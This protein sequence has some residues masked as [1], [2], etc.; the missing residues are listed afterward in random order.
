LLAE[1]NCDLQRILSRRLNLLGLEVVSVT[2]GREAVTLAQAALV[3]EKPFDLIL[4][5]I[6]MPIVDGYEATRQ[7][8]D[9]GFSGPILAL[10]AHSAEDYRQE[11][12]K[13]GCNDCI[14]KPIDWS[15]LSVL[16]REHIARS[17]A[18]ALLSTT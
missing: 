13:M 9:S 2:N 15:L 6:E 5:D 16:I 11:C 14:P 4:M 8:R 3:G 17:R 1:D 7:I 18:L 10:S 12:I